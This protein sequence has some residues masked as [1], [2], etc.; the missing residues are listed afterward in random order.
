[1][2]SA[3]PHLVEVDL[4]GER[5][6]LK[7][8]TVEDVIKFDEQINSGGDDNLKPIIEFLEGL[9]VRSGT[10]ENFDFDDIN[11]IVE[12]LIGSGERVR[13]SDYQLGKMAN[14]Y[15]WTHEYLLSMESKVFMKYYK[16]IPVIESQNQINSFTAADWPNM[17]KEKRKELFNKLQ[18]LAKAANPRKKVK[19][20]KELLSSIINQN[21]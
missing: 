12:A 1:M 3:S 14:F 13:F 21:Q 5:C 2:E 6:F 7:S 19:F 16:I 17:K 10:V 9:G 4:Y 20:T 11:P 15:G 18:K 8:P